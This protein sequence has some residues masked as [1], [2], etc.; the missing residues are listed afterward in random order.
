MNL[1]IRLVHDRLNVVFM[2][3]LKKK[4]RFFNSIFYKISIELTYTTIFTYKRIE[5]H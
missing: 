4:R 3:N 5:T 2:V 1:F